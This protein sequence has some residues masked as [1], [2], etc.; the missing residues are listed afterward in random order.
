MGVALCGIPEKIRDDEQIWG[1]IWED[2]RG[3][4]LVELKYGHRISRLVENARS[5]NESRG[6]TGV[7]VGSHL[8]AEHSNARGGERIVQ[9]IHHSGFPVR[10]RYPKNFF[11]VG[12][13]AEKI[14]ADLNSQDAGEL[15]A[16]VACD[17][18]S[19]HGEF[20]HEKRCKK[21][22]T[23]HCFII[24]SGLGNL[25]LCSAYLPNDVNGEHRGVRENAAG[26]EYIA[27]ERYSGRYAMGG[28]VCTNMPL[29][30]DT[31][32]VGR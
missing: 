28:D 4:A 18:Q 32:A 15:S 24:S 3:G 2:S 25:S 16:V 26:K 7:Q 31:C 29:S 30:S 11:G 5:H 12:D 13:P 10:T 1:K 19:Q 9:Q 22:N 8:I 6:H 23:V 27:I 14:W 17:F 20:G 21:S